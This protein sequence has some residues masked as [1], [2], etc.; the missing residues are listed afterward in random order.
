MPSLVCLVLHENHP[1]CESILKLALQKRLHGAVRI[2]IRLSF[3]LVRFRRWTKFSTD[4]R[5]NFCADRE[6]SCEREGYPHEYS[7]VRIFIRYRVN[8]V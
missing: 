3:K 7:S 5:T 2:F 6:V 4:S 8:G 1:R